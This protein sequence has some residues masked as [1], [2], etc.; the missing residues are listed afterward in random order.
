MKKQRKTA[1]IISIKDAS[2]VNPLGTVLSGV[3]RT[4]APVNIGGSGE[5]WKVTFLCDDDSLFTATIGGLHRKVPYET[6]SKGLLTVKGDAMI[7]WEPFQDGVNSEESLLSFRERKRRKILL[8]TGIAAMLLAAAAVYFVLILA[9]REKVSKVLEA[10]DGSRVEIVLTTDRRMNIQEQDSSAIVV[11]FR[12]VL[13][14]IQ[15]PTV[16]EKNIELKEK[17]AAL[18]QSESGVRFGDY[19]N[20][21][22]L[23]GTIYITESQRNLTEIF[24][25]DSLKEYEEIL[26]GQVRESGAPVRISGE[27]EGADIL[28]LLSRLEFE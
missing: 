28:R 14:T 11:N 6:G 24:E 20:D 13:Y 2:V 3:D 22:G 16:I 19:V 21:D 15:V 26:L 8:F 23:S 27:G 1:E 12:S 9:S 10:E 5:R 25:V 4:G 17:Q 7:A 18:N